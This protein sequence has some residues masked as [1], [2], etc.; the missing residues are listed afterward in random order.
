MRG[1]GDEVESANVLFLDLD[2]FKQVNDSLGHARGDQLLTAVAR[3]LQG[4]VR[5]TDIVARWGGDEFAILQRPVADAGQ[6][7]ELAEQILANPSADVHR[8]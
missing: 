7:G 2:D 1:R 4:I 3:R 6:A 5:D 8:G